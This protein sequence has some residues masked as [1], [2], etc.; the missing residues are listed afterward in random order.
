MKFGIIPTE[1][2]RFYQ[3]ATREVERAEELGFD[4]AWIEEH[5]GVY[6]HYWPSPLMVLAG[7]ATRTSEIMLGTDIIVLPFYHP[8]RLAE[9][10][11]MLDIMSGGRFILG[12][13]IGYRPQEF[14]LYDAPMEKRGGRFEEALKML[15]LLWSSECVNFEGQ[16][17]QLRDAR[18]EPRPEKPIPI[19]VGGWGPLSLRRAAALADAWVPGPTASLEKLLAAQIIYHNHL[20]ELG[21]DPAQTPTPLTREV[22]IAPTD[23]EARELAERHLLINYRDEYGKDWSHP[24]IGNED[25]APVDQFEALSKDRFIIGGPEQCIEKIRRFQDAF[26]VDHLI[27]RL[28]FPGIS[29]QRILDELELLANEVLPVFKSS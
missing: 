10:S 18:I 20:I 28:Y 25:Q 27:C 5:H 9:D 2:G 19:W 24:L 13:A 23:K 17:Y 26:G 7:W 16:Y 3:E 12:A 1:G 29:H 6:N 4:S 11:A 21:L 15:K 14:E 22:I 8:V